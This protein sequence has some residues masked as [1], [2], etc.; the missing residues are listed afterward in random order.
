MIGAMVAEG[1]TQREIA[2]NFGFED[3]KIVR[4]ALKRERRKARQIPKTRGCKPAKILQEYKY[5][6]ICRR[7]T[8]G[9]VCGFDYCLGMNM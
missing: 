1:T 9:M 7:N 3:K 2:E 5:L 4:E 6:V 8:I